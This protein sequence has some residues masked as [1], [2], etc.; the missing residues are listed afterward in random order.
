MQTINPYFSAVRRAD[1][2]IGDGLRAKARR[3]KHNEGARAYL[4][5]THSYKLIGNGHE[6]GEQMV[7]T[8][9]QALAQ[10]EVLLGIYREDIQAEIDAG[11]KYGQ[12]AS[13]LK[14]WVVVARHVS[15]NVEDPP[16]SPAQDSMG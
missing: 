13:V 6:L 7:M 9:R 11:V 10:N 8:G 5:G 15:E 2:F 3:R 1:K 14:R 16:N 4:D 12:T